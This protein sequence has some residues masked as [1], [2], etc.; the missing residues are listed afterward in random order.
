MS[1]DLKGFTAFITGGS[2]GMGFEMARELLG[3]GA[4][5]AIAARG[6]SKLDDAYRRLRTEGR[7]VHAVAL[8]VRDN[9][10]V[11]AASVWFEQNFDHLDMLVNNAGIG[12]NASG[13]RFGDPEFRFY[14]LPV[15]TFTTIVETN[16][17]G[18]FLVS[19]AFVPMMVRRGK[20]K[21]VNVSTGTQTMTQKGMIPYG[22]SKAGAEAMSMVLSEDLADLG[23]A[24]NIIC[25]GGVTDTE[26]TTD[27][28]RDALSEHNVP[29]L[30]ASVM[31]RALLFLASPASDGLTGEK[32]VGKDFDDWLRSRNI[33]FDD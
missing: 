30:E 16:F 22:P 12:E 9:E 14:D 17:T 28:M 33:A 3:H 7:D 11:E 23:I 6:G 20:R 15:S 2:S 10:S 1:I 21:L 32:I 26:M 8:D 19:R 27:A 24:V 5:V 13:M 4:T 25:P 31:N 18:S 29:M